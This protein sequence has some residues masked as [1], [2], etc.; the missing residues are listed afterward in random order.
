[1]RVRTCVFV[2]VCALALPSAHAPSFIYTGIEATR[3]LTTHVHTRPSNARP[4]DAAP[5]HLSTCQ[6]I[7]WKRNIGREVRTIERT[8]TGACVRACLPACLR[9]GGSIQGGTLICVRYRF[10]P[11]PRPPCIARRHRPGGA[12]NREG[13]QK[14]GQ[15]G[16]AGVHRHAM[17]CLRTRVRPRPRSLIHTPLESTLPQGDSRRGALTILAKDLVRPLSL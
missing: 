12:E 8:M 9:V 16:A 4:D 7:Q 17:P 1:M 6:Y 14:A 2:Y 11:P 10:P 13:D 5:P 15:G 3:A